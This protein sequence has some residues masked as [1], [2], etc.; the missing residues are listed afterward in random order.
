MRIKH[1]FFVPLALALCAPALAQKVNRL[2]VYIGFRE[3]EA[4]V[5]K[6]ISTVV[7]WHCGPASLGVA[8]YDRNMFSIALSRTNDLRN[9]KSLTFRVAEV[10]AVPDADITAVT[11]GGV[12]FIPRSRTAPSDPSRVEEELGFKYFGVGS[13]DG[14][15]PTSFR[16]GHFT[17]A[18]I[19]FNKE[20]PVTVSWNRAGTDRNT[21]MASVLNVRLTTRDGCRG[22]SKLEMMIE[23]YDGQ[24]IHIPVGTI[25]DNATKEINKVLQ[26]PIPERG[27][28]KVH[29]WFNNRNFESNRGIRN[30]DPFAQPDDVDLA[31]SIEGRSR[32]VTTSFASNRRVRLLNWQ[33]A[34]STMTGT[35]SRAFADDYLNELTLFTQTGTNAI[36][37]SGRRGHAMRISGSVRATDGTTYH[38]MT[39]AND[40]T[41][42]GILASGTVTQGSLATLTSNRSNVPRTF[43]LSRLDSVTVSIHPLA[44]PGGRDVFTESW[45]MA[46]LAIGMRKTG[47]PTD[48]F[49]Q[50][51]LFADMA[52]NM[53]FA[54]N[55]NTTGA[56]GSSTR[57]FPFR[58]EQI[59][60]TLAFR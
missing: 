13:I 56:R 17:G 47:D 12:P 22:D 48:I 46:G 19:R 31:Y 28:S 38:M 10:G 52:A 23:T 45:D 1:L 16:P 60:Y 36:D 5:G 20:N 33:N 41:S 43:R 7:E 2:Q 42:G 53:P 49:T 18:S 34:V 25:G 15:Q 44:T 8:T 55:F 6:K 30:D 3:P 54:Y 57:S 24:F 11:V 14:E 37:W 9:L 27:I 40:S 51:S 4:M 35:R 39:H 21:V 29:F 26:L 59:T 58:G 50:T 32:G